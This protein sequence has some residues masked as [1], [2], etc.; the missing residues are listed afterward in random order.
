MINLLPLEDKRQIRAG[1][2]NSLLIRYNIFL[3][4]ALI[5]LIMAI[6][7]TYVYLNSAKSSAEQTIKDNQTRVASFAPVEAKAEAFRTNL[8]IAKQ[9]LDREVSYSKVVLE[10]A[11]LLPSGVVLGNLDLDAQTF[12]T[13]TVLA[14]QA[15]S[16]ASALSL[17]DAFQKST[18]F[19]NVHFQSITA[20]GTG[21]YP[22]TVNLG[23]T[24]RKDS[25]K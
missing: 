23:V 14:A 15:K 12:G 5:F 1:R 17:K 24:I 7:V 4:G 11:Q 2:T 19:S 9:I 21:S 13:E 3:F 18:I 10:I 25:A 20:G 8:S 16:Y 22:Y 6:L